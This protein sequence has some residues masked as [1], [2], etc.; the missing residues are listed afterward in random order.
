[1]FKVL[2]RL[3]FIYSY[4]FIISLKTGGYIYICTSINVS[5]N[6]IELQL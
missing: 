4:Q 1:M 6:S 3:D 2:F 5:Y